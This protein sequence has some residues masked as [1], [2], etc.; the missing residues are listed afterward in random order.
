M[1]RRE[2]PL[3]QWTTRLD[4]GCAA[5]EA[6][7]FGQPLTRIISSRS[8]GDRRTLPEPRNWDTLVTEGFRRVIT[9]S[10]G[11][12]RRTQMRLASV[13]RV[14]PADLPQPERIFNEHPVRCRNCNRS[15]PPGS[16]TITAISATFLRAGQW[17][18]PDCV[19]RSAPRCANCGRVFRHGDDRRLN[20]AKQLVHTGGCPRKR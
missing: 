16:I 6:A 18:C 9:S 20:H 11:G 5:I 13:T 10:T 1:N 7:E 3:P 19:Y 14:R 12:D 4:G 8:S 2:T 15:Y 17:R